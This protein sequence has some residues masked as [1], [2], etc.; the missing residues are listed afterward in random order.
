MGTAANQ[1]RTR[2]DFNTHIRTGSMHYINSAQYPTDPADK[3][4][5]KCVTKRECDGIDLIWTNTAIDNTKCITNV[6]GGYTDNQNITIYYGIYNDKGTRAKLDYVSVQLSTSNDPNSG[7]WHEIKRVDPG[8]VPANGKK[9]GSITFNLS[10][11]R[12]SNFYVLATGQYYLCVRVGDT[13]N[14]QKWERGWGNSDHLSD[15]SSLSLLSSSTKKGYTTAIPFQ[16]EPARYN[17]DWGNQIL[18]S[19][20][21]KTNPYNYTYIYGRS[22]GAA[23]LFRIS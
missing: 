17:S 6:T 12:P 22:T 3:Y 21:V 10:V 2:Y 15:V 9:T 5:Y 8:Y 14:K 7:T 1:V 23:A 13:N 20:L 16:M 11:D 18:T 19:Y 4:K